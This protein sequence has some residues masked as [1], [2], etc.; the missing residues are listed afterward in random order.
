[1]RQTSERIVRTATALFI[2]G[3]ALSELTLQPPV[4]QSLEVLGYP[5]Y[6]LW[7]L[8]PLKLLAV[9]TLVVP[10][11][12]PWRSFALLGLFFNLLGA[13]ASF[14]FAGVALLPDIVIAPTVLVLV[15]ATL[16]LQPLERA[17]L[18]RVSPDALPVAPQIALLGATGL[19]GR[20]VLELALE[21]GVAVR[22][23]VRREDA[24]APR[25]GLTVIVGD[26]TDEATV[27]RA[28]GDAPL[29]ISALGPR[30]GERGEVS[31]LATAHLIR[32]LAH[33]ERRLAIVSSAAV[34][35]AGDAP[36]F[37][38]FVAQRYVRRAYPSSLD[39]KI[40][41][42]ALLRTAPVIATLYRPV[43]IFDD[44]QAPAREVR[45]SAIEPVGLRIGARA[46]A[47]LLLAP[48]LLG[49]PHA[50]PFVASA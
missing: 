41:E 35:R 13:S 31:A 8:A 42:A 6:L 34:A 5:L 39:A 48:P 20:A 45:L 36:R 44:R 37:T 46:L 50:A 17:Q 27:R 1:M 29:V 38:S 2:T 49:L 19:T 25:D 10:W 33:T 43:T 16:A 11:A 15:T 21:R 32:A 24:L 3:A 26:A 9:L 22:A 40:R 47:A 12:A 14:L 7:I 4:V 18:L 28:I 30:E 23:L